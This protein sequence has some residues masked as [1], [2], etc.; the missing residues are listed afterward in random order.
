MRVWLALAGL[1]GLLAVVAGALGSH[2]LRSLTAE[3]RTAFET[4]VRYQAIH[5]LALLGVALLVGQGFTGWPVRLAGLGF[6]LGAL[7]FCG[8]LYARAL[9]D[10][11]LPVPLAPVGGLAMMAGWAALVVAAIV[12]RP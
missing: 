11:H 8:A 3:A 6:A 12:G 9:F 5:A 2:A 4:A 7:L 1:Y 10:A